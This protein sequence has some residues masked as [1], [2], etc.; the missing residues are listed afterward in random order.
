MNVIIGI[1]A[2]EGGSNGPSQAF[3]K[4]EE[5]HSIRIVDNQTEIIAGY[6][7]NGNVKHYSYAC[8]LGHKKRISFTNTN[9]YLSVAHI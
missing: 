9:I 7:W 2:F 4:T 3:T 6:L 8:F 1:R 5:N